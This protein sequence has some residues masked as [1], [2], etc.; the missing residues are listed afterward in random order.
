MRNSEKCGAAYPGTRVH[1]YGS[2]SGMGTSIATSVPGY[3]KVWLRQKNLPVSEYLGTQVGTY[4][5]QT[6]AQFFCYE[7][8]YAHTTATR[9]GFPK[10]CKWNRFGLIPEQMTET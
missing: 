6:K 1:G 5:T 10:R 3:D 7:R 9:V 4:D 8:H 2:I